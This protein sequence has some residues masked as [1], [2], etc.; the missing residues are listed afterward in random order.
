MSPLSVLLTL[1]NNR[2]DNLKLIRDSASST[3][4]QKQDAVTEIVLLDNIKT[5]ITTYNG[6]FLGK[7]EVLE[8]DITILNNFQD[9][10][11]GTLRGI[12]EDLDNK[13]RN[14]LREIDNKKRMVQ[15]NTYYSKKYADYIYIAKLTILLCAIIIILSM[16]VRRSIISN[17][18]YS[19]LI[20]FCCFV[21]IITII[22]TLISM[23]YRDQIDYS[24]YNFY[25]PSDKS[26]KSRSVGGKTTIKLGY[27]EPIIDVSST[28]VGGISTLLESSGGGGSSASNT[29]TGGVYSL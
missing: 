4:L 15:I 7:L 2:I 29:I 1:V 19:I 8:S 21:I 10:V 13:Q 22:Y 28:S 6:S 5:S 9:T 25:I 16:L 14:A 11:Y 18:L 17:G 12:N 26:K 23:R 24:K 3:A 27:G 20:G